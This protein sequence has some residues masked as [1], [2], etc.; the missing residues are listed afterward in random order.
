MRYFVCMSSIK[1]PTFPSVDFSS[2]DLSK[3]PQVKMP[4]LAMPDIDTDAV[5][6]AIKD[7]GY[8]TVGL[9]VLTAQKAQVR[10]Q[11]LKKSLAAQVGDG[12]SQVAEIV[13]GIEAG[14]ASLDNRLVAIE[15]K[16]DSAVD[17]LEKRLPAR[18]GDVLGQVHEVAKV[19]RQQVRNLIAPA[20]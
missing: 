17:A 2:L 13:E 5:T 19:A 4:R 18:A 6:G 15:T 14:L 12:R 20:A 8:V 11:E 16:V 1:F 9:V 10:R 3:L 7:A